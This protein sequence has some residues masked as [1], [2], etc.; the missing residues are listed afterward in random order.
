MAMTEKQVIQ[1]NDTIKVILKVK[2]DKYQELDDFYG[3]V[4]DKVDEWCVDRHLG[5]LLGESVPEPE[6]SERQS[7]LEDELY[8]L[9]KHNFQKSDMPD[10]EYE[11]LGMLRA[12]FDKKWEEW[13]KYHGL[14]VLSDDV[15]TNYR[16]DWQ[17]YHPYIENYEGDTEENKIKY[18]LEDYKTF[19]RFERGDWCYIYY[20]ATV[21]VDNVEVAE[22]TSD[23]I[24]SNA[25]RCDKKEVLRN[26]LDKCFSDIKEKIEAEITSLQDQVIS[27]K[28]TLQEL[29]ENSDELEQMVIKEINL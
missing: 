4:S 20:K 1:V 24:E 13:N 17:F 7:E 8:A 19:D 26:L 23:N 12:E 16:S 6:W 9:S 2:Y 14:K 25:D 11:E 18:C 5:V 27:L 21:L 28:V 3:K 10:E 22:E 15:N 29:P